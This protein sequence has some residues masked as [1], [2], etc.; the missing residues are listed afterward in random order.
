[1]NLIDY[2]THESVDQ[3][4]LTEKRAIEMFKL[5]GNLKNVYSFIVKSTFGNNG[6]CKY[7]L[8]T[9]ADKLNISKSTAFRSVKKLK[10]LNLIEV[11]EGTKLNGIKGA[12]IYA[13]IFLSQNDHADDHASVVKVT[14][15]EKHETPTGSKDEH[16]KNETQ[17][18]GFKLS[19]N[20]YVNN[21]NNVKARGESYG[22]ALAIKEI[23]SSNNECTEDQLNELVKIGL[24][25]IKKYTSLY[26]LEYTQLEQIVLNCIQSLSNK[27]GVKNVFGMYS[28]MIKRQV[29]QIVK[30]IQKPFKQLLN[31]SKELIPDWY[32]KRNERPSVD[33][34]V[35]IDFELERQK[36]LSKLQGVN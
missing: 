16:T 13:V 25:S 11:H 31:K 22:I 28:A 2:A 14:T 15:R 26:Q 7:L 35:S 9:I 33:D 4:K 10:E 21:V 20:P 3:L 34:K 17:S 23:Y 6:A 12:N 30:P 8:Q 32:E 27:T 1:M 29:E 19:F 18:L 24:G 5:K 36:I